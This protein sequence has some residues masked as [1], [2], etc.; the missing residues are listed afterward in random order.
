[1][2]HA[3]NNV[4]VFALAGALGDGVATYEVPDGVGL[5]HLAISLATMAAYVVLVRHVARRLRPETHTAAQ[6]LRVAPAPLPAPSW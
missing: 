5:L 6:D 1:M 2:L 3:V 4:L